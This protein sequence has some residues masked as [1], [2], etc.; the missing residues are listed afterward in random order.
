MYHSID[1]LFMC[2][3]YAIAEWEE[4]VRGHYGTVQVE[5]ETFGLDDRLFQSIDT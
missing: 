3:L 4:G 5:P 1:A 2:D